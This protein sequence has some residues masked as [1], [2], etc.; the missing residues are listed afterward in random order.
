[1][2]NK[3]SRVK[4]IPHEGYIINDRIR[5]REL[6]LIDAD[7]RN[8]GMVS[9]DTAMRMAQEQSI[10]VVQI[11]DGDGEEGV[12]AK[13]MDF[14]RF[15][16]EKKKQ[17][18]EAKKKQKVILVK[19]LKMRPR[20]GDGDYKIR[21]KKAVQFLS[22]GKRVKFT[23]QFRGREMASI[24]SVGPAFFVRIQEDL[25]ELGV[26]P[27]LSDRESRGGPFLSKVFYLKGK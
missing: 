22:E 10:D 25:D 1:V 12:V 14:G 13:L 18:H 15:L 5:A 16:Y 19:E 11:G 21:L 26:G 27:L 8:I 4:P 2:I 6:R 17:Q 23:I 9:T 7:G 3:R 24:D 20:I